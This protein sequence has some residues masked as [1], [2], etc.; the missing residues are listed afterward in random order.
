MVRFGVPQTRGLVEGG[1]GGEAVVGLLD[2]RVLEAVVSAAIGVLFEV[3]DEGGHEGGAG[4]DNDVAGGV[5]DFG[6]GGEGFGGRE[7]GHGCLEEEAEG[8]A[9]GEGFIVEEGV[10]EE[11]AT[12]FGEVLT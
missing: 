2:D 3:V 10:E 7:E 5:E 11:R 1:I 8:H 6:D 12:G 9:V 4:G